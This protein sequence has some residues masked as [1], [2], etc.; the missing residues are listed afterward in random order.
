MENDCIV[1][2][3]IILHSRNYGNH[4]QQRPNLLM[5]TTYEGQVKKK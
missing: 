4:T 1:N 3:N 2:E 5:K